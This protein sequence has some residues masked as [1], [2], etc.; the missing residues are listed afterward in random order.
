MCRASRLE[1]RGHMQV[2]RI[3]VAEASLNRSLPSAR[4]RLHLAAT[5]MTGPPDPLERAPCLS[6]AVAREIN[7]CDQTPVPRRQLIVFLFQKRR[8]MGGRRVVRGERF[9]QRFSVTIPF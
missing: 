2:Q 5:H 7:P 1:T 9:K 6:M 3:Q 4:Q 8:D